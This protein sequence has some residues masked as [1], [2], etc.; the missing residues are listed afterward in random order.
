MRIG[1]T[2]RGGLVLALRGGLGA[3][4]TLL[5]KGIAKG[6]GIEEE[7][8]SPTYTIISEYEGRLRLHHVDAWRLSDADEFEAVGASD[9]LSD[10]GGLTVIEWSEKVEEL[11]PPERVAI[12]LLVGDDESRVA[13][14]SGPIPE[15]WMI[16]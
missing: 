15:E 2:A 14:L 3:G 10:L 5:T 1:E 11:L 9:I 16:Q 13:L 8:T 4:K 12:E 6:L 7:V